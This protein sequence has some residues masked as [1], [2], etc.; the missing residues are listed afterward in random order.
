MR[1]LKIVRIFERRAKCIWFEILFLKISKLRKSYMAII[2]VIFR[3]KSVIIE[4]FIS[5]WG[6]RSKKNKVKKLVP[7]L[8]YQQNYHQGVNLTVP[9]GNFG[10]KK[11]LKWNSSCYSV[12]KFSRKLCVWSSKSHVSIPLCYLVTIFRNQLKMS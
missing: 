3:S 4:V 6:V 7:N 1:S 5:K 9:K 10:L 12:K 11:F 8:E 2:M